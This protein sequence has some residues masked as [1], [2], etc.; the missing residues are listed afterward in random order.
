MNSAQRNYSTTEK[1]C[2]TVIL[3]IE[4]FR[5]YIELMEFTVIT[6]QS[7]L[8]WFMRP[9]D[10]KGRLAKWSLKLQGYNFSIEHHI[11]RPDMLSCINMEEI[12]IENA[13]M[14][15]YNSEEFKK[16]NI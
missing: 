15:D 16:A 14:I 5:Q 13:S 12:A 7:S 4:R 8:Q 3:A 1:E 11:R 6:D 10:L 9:K 2:L